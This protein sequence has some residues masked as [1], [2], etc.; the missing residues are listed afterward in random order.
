LD[1]A[2]GEA[3]IGSPTSIISE[4]ATTRAEFG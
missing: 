4:A 3:T 2:D 1:G